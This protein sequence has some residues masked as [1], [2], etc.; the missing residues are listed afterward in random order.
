MQY[1]MDPCNKSLTTD[2]GLIYDK[3]QTKWYLTKKICD[4]EVLKNKIGL[5]P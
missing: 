3:R 2:I 1:Q 5:R 4:A